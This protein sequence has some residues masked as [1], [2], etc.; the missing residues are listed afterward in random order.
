V[1]A[2]EIG[3]NPR[4]FIDTT[5]HSRLWGDIQRA[6]TKPVTA[7]AAEAMAELRRTL[8]PISCP[9][10]SPKGFLTISGFSGADETS[11]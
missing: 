9:R 8:W 4:S 11:L 6:A 5:R 1:S 2:R 10:I 3:D 7:T